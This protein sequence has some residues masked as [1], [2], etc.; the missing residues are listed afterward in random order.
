MALVEA[1]RDEECAC[2]T[3]RTTDGTAFVVKA[4]AD[5]I[6]R[7]SGPLSVAVAH[8]LYAA[9][10][11]PVLRTLLIFRDDPQRPFVVETFTNIADPAQRA[12][13]AQLAEQETAA[14]EFY[15]EGFTRRLTKRIT[16]GGGNQLTQVLAHAQ[17]YRR[18][19]P[20]GGY[21]FDRANSD[22]MAIAP[23]PPGLPAGEETLQ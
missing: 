22:V 11:A 2:V 6:D 1:M 10:T 17:E 15:D 21:D 7:L 5:E 18:R 12:D 19:I 16:L 8:E 14:V 9:A 13:F 20:E 4:P 3:A 23:W